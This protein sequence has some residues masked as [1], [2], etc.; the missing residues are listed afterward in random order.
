MHTPPQ[1]EHPT[2]TLHHNL[3]TQHCN[4]ATV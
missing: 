4:T 3:N 1:P 2:R